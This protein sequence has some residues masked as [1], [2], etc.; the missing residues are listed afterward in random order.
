LLVC[1]LSLC[2][3]T[4]VGG[5]KGDGS[6]HYRQWF[7]F[8]RARLRRYNGRLVRFWTLSVRS[9]SVLIKISTRHGTLSDESQEKIRAK[10]ERLERY[11]E[12]LTSIEVTID[13][14]SSESPAVQLHV[15]A[16]HKHD[17]VASEETEELFKSVDSVVQK[18]E[19]QLRRY[20]ERIQGHHRGNM[21]GPET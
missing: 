10:V 11:F 12:R 14:K 19:E 21:S 17:F 20:K 5:A 13:M 9:R 1:R 18:M 16:E 3:G 2:D 4:V 7:A 8:E 6:E 15:S